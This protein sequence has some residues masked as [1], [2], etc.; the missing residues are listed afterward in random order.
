MHQRYNGL[1]ATVWSLGILLYDM[2]AGD[3]PFH[4]DYEICGGTI[5]WRREVSAGI[6]DFFNSFKIQIKH[7]FF[8]D[9]QDLIM[10][11]LEVDPDRRC[12]LEEI[13][14]HPWMNAGEIRSLT[15]DELTLRKTPLKG[16]SDSPTTTLTQQHSIP[17]QVSQQQPKNQLS[18]IKDSLK[19][20]IIN[21]K[22]NK[23]TFKQLKQQHHSQPPTQI[24]AIPNYYSNIKNNNSNNNN[25]I[26]RWREERALN[27]DEDSDE[28]G[29]CSSQITQQQQKNLQSFGNRKSKEEI[30]QMALNN[31]YKIP[32][33]TTMGSF[34]YTV[35]PLLSTIKDNNQQKYNCSRA[36]YQYN[37]YCCR[38]CKTT[39]CSSDQS[40]PSAVLYEGK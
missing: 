8:K 20:S 1:K 29:D 40:L 21:N 7:L 13:L 32:N 27:Y 35:E 12:T 15:T 19:H 3:I 28:Y 38:G 14:S 10:R 26:S 6:F 36:F 22:N 11:C 33:S 24:S 9:C 23:A 5:R 18:I 31:G 34:S 37:E 16:V 25:T 4:R 2:I 30:N 17:L 39:S